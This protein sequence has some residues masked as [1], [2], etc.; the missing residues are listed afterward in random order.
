MAMCAWKK[1]FEETCCVQGKQSGLW[2]R[3]VRVVRW[4]RIW[5]AQGVGMQNKGKAEGSR[6]AVAGPRVRRKIKERKKERSW[7]GKRHS[8]RKTCEVEKSSSISKHFINC[9]LFCIQI[10][11]EI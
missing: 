2:G 8:V 7:A 5:A 11:F 6:W 9:K 3:L 10:K 1:W 4:K